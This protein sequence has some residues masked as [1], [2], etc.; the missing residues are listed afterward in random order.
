M[1]KKYIIKV[2]SNPSF[3][4]ID[5]GGV[6]FANG[7]AIINES[8][9]VEWFRTHEGYSV[10][11]VKEKNKA[12]EP[13]DPLDSMKVE[14]LKAYAAEKNIDLGDV[15]KKADI[16]AAIRNEETDEEEIAE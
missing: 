4:G 15:T 10:T 13:K 5:A 12:E 8:Y 16:I 9:L 7:K 11:E 1:T 14:D 3:C 2:E 6:Q